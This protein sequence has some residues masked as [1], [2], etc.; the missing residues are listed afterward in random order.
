MVFKSF[1]RSPARIFAE[2]SL[3]IT[4]GGP[5]S[6]LYVLESGEVEVIRHGIVVATISD[7]G[8]I[9]GE[10]SVL[11]DAPHS[12]TVRAKTTVMAHVVENAREALKKRPE[13]TYKV[14]QILARRLGATTS[15]LVESR[16]KL[17]STSDLAFLEKVYE[18][19]GK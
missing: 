9:I 15:F 5:P 13:L 12:A 17:E 18:L 2:G 7:V 6:N 4:E 10:M 19:L 16:E 1:D 3:I 8:A 11:L 14:A